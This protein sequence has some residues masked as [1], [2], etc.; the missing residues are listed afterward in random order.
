MVLFKA[1]YSAET[2]NET[3]TGLSDHDFASNANRRYRV[4]ALDQMDNHHVLC[5]HFWQLSDTIELTSEWSNDLLG[6][7]TAGYWL[8][9]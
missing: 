2:S 3:Y 5:P 8:F 6:I 1:Q 7:G 4:T 9:G